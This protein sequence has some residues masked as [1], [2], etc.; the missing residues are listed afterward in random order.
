MTEDP[1]IAVTTARH[2]HSSKARVSVPDTINFGPN[3]FRR[4]RI[5]KTG[6]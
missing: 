6:V 1:E 2:R 4:T 3:I 5:S